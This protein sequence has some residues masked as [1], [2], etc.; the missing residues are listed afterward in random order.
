MS[1]VGIVT[2]STPGI[3]G[4][5]VLMVDQTAPAPRTHR[6]RPPASAG[7]ASTGCARPTLRREA[8]AHAARIPSQPV[9]RPTGVRD[10]IDAEPRRHQP[11][12]GQ[13][14]G[15]QPSAEVV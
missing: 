10:R 7:L 3:A 15:V 6:S 2:K 14:G 12:P 13:A 8:N 5:V 9:L 4:A 1:S 11:P